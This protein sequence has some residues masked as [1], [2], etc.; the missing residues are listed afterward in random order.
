MMHKW[1]VIDNLLGKD[2]VEALIDTL[3]NQV[4]DFPDIH[5]RFQAAMKQLH[6]TYGPEAKHD[7]DQYVEAV[8]QKCSALLFYTGVQG[9]K[10]NYDHFLN[11]IAPTCVW[12][13]V[14]FDDFLR[15]ELA[16]SMPLYESASRF[17]CAFPMQIPN[18]VFEAVSDYESTL[19]VYGMKLAHYNGYLIGN[20]LLKHCVPGYRPDNL[21]TDRYRYML[22]AYFGCKFPTIQS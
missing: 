20:D 18:D 21:L 19:E 17:I 11:P 15:T 6:E 5:S 12:P 8:V 10:M 4:S 9:L 1:K 14:D 13:Q 3:N 16:Y 22:E 2:T 7:I